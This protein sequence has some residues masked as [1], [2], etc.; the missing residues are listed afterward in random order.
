M[1]VGAHEPLHARPLG[2]FLCRRRVGCDPVSRAAG[3]QSDL[4]QQYSRVPHPGAVHERVPSE[5][6]EIRLPAQAIAGYVVIT[7]VVIQI[8]QAVAVRRVVRLGSV[9]EMIVGLLLI[10]GVK[11][12]LGNVLG[13]FKLAVMADVESSSMFAGDF[14]S[15]RG[16]LHLDIAFEH[17]Y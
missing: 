15:T 7:A 12:G 16:P 11:W 1:S 4:V 8:A 2:G 13:Q 6:G 10:P 9:A 17:S 14:D 5:A 3:G